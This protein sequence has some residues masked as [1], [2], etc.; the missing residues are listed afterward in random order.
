MDVRLLW[1]ALGAFAGSVES[2]LIVSVLPAIAA[3]TGV[4]LAQAGYLIFGYS[5]APM[6]SA[7]PCSQR[8]SGTSTA[9]RWSR[10]PNC[11]SA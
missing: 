5:I 2:S 6:A 9:A 1:L 3:E 8:S 4:S 11:S 7:R 10:A